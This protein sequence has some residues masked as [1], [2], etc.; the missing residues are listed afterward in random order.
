MKLALLLWMASVMPQPMAAHTCLAT[1]VYLE[2]RSQP[3]IGQKAVAEVILRRRQEGHWG[4]SVCD[5]VKS[6]H[7]FAITATPNSYELTDLAAWKKAWQVAGKSLQAWEK[8]ADQRSLVVPNADHFA[9]VDIRTKWTSVGVLRTIG[10]HAFYA[11][12]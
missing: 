1:T 10:D 4:D 2:A 12:N 11:V 8:P 5:V 6:P 9:T 7:Q 3:T